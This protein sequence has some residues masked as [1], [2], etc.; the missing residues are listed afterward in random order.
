MQHFECHQVTTLEINTKNKKNSIPND[1]LKKIS[2]YSRREKVSFFK[3]TSNHLD[4][5]DESYL[6]FCF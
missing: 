3:A 6:L 4:L 1:F 5:N 2:I